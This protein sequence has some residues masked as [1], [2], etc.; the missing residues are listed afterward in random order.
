LEILTGDFNPSRNMIA[1]VQPKVVFTE[2]A[3]T[4]VDVHDNMQMLSDSK[5]VLPAF[6]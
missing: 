3:K 2:T 1:S 5:T 4:Y 6:I